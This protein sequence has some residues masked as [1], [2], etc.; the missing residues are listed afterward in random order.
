M[1]W[2]IKSLLSENKFIIEK[3]DISGP[4]LTIESS[5]FYDYYVLAIITFVNFL[6]VEN[7]CDETIHRYETRMY[8]FFPNWIKRVETD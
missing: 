7:Q 4:C 3:K 5:S 2:S 6:S 8:F 1:D